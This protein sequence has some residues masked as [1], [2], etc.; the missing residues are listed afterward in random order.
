[1]GMFRKSPE[2]WMSGIPLDV[3]TRGSC[4]T[5]KPIVF[6]SLPLAEELMAGHPGGAS[7]DWLMVSR[8]V[9]VEVFTP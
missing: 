1:M 4:S 8:L 2:A 7:V 6:V 9:R 3:G 5:I